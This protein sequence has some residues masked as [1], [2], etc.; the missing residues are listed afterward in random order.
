M[1]KTVTNT[2]T[3]T[4]M[5]EME[6]ETWAKA[7]ENKE[8]A[9]ALGLRLI[10]FAKQPD[11]LLKQPSLGDF[12]DKAQRWAVANQMKAKMLLMRLAKLFM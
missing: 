2:A 7:P 4:E 11:E 10:R 5:N 1:E 12:E 3:S 9:K 6:I 8:R